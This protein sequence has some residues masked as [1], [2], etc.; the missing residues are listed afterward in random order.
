MNNIQSQQ[1]IKRIPRF[2]FPEFSGEWK[3]KK[4]EEIF[5][6]YI[7]RNHNGNL[8]LLAVTQDK[9]V[10]E[11]NDLDLRINSSEKGIKSYKIIEAG[12]FVISLR[13]FQGGI[14]YSKIKGISSPAY[15]VLKSKIKICDDFFKIFFKRQEFINKL[16]TLIYGIR[17]GKQISYKEF[18]NLKLPFLDLS[19]QEKI[20][21]FLI[22]VDS[23]I[24]NL[25]TQKENLEEYKKGIMQKI[26]SQ[27]IRF[28]D[29]NGKSFSKWEEKK[30]GE[31]LILS[32]KRNKESNISLV[33][34][35]NN[36]KGFIAQTEQF[37]D[38]RVASRE[39][40]N[41]RIVEKGDF[42][43]NPSR[44]NVGSIACLKNFDTG[45]VSPMY[46]VFKLNNNLDQVFF[47]NLIKTHY[48]RYLIKI[49][50]SGSVRDTLNFE[51]MT[52]FKLRFPEIKEQQ[53]IA[54]FLNS[55]DKA[56]EAK[57]QQI[58]LA[59]NW[60]KGLMQGLFI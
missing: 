54:D 38:H 53:K 55:L 10:V 48:F 2:R 33:L 3:E 51:D 32:Q 19:E 24:E 15:T 7:N 29:D 16:N 26:F 27:E 28:K 59:E 46:V 22:I 34:S 36:K 50:C 25:Q 39:V 18:K 1:N 30:L 37:E 12:N 40:L 11:R 60:K 17:D 44:I 45:I 57:Q 9:G 20:A 42:A 23:W 35:V 21:S 4:A 52:K 56:I 5:D 13:S 6:N 41:Y 49:G 8:P 43:Y 47:E 58:T 14:E 31:Y